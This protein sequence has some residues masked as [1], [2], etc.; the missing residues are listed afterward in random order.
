[1][2]DEQPFHRIIYFSTLFYFLFPI[3]IFILGWMPWFLSAPLLIFMLYSLV[4][5]FQGPRVMSEMNQENDLPLP[6]WSKIFS[7]M[8]VL[9]IWTYLSGVGGNRFQNGDF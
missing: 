5:I 6:S 3:F 4:T 2:Y 9:F 8:F 7:I 1:M